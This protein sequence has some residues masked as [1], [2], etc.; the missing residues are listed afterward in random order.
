MRI[1]G[2]DHLVLTVKSIE[3]TVA[4]FRQLGFAEVHFGEGR[5]AL[6]CGEHK[7]NLHESGREF[8]PKAKSPT[9]GSAD[10]CFR[11]ETP[12]QQVIAELGA[13]GIPIESG[14]AHRTG[15]RA[16][17]LSVYL[18]DPDGNLIEL[19]NELA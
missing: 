10:L 12:L 16:G 4:F 19:S 13:A 14:P 17:L 5:V 6:Q 11:V 2:L 3:A 8:E 15:A 7:L 1:I 9:S 18:R